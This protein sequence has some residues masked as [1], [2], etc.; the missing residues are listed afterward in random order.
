MRLVVVGNCL[1]F[2]QSS[3][4]RDVAAEQLRRNVEIRNG[5]RFAGKELSLSR[6][7]VSNDG[8]PMTLS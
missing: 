2:G 1:G 5:S 6:W 3:S 8:R 7:L 4:G